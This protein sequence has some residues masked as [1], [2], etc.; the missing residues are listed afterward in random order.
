MMGSQVGHCH[1]VASIWVV[2]A[3]GTALAPLGMAAD[4]TPSLRVAVMGPGSP[5]PVLHCCEPE[6]TEPRM[7]DG[8]S[9]CSGTKGPAGPT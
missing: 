7:P 8:C 4:P 9:L 2:P 5:R 1:P 3:P 6:R